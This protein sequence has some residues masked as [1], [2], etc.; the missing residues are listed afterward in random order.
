MDTVIERTLVL[1]KADVLERGLLGRVLQ[2][3]EDTGLKI[4]AA[5]LIQATEETARQHYAGTKAWKQRI[6]EKVKVA[7]SEVKMDIKGYFGTQDSL[8]IGQII[9]QW[10][11]DYLVS[12]PVL[13]LVI[14]GPHAV[15]RV[16]EI[17]GH[18]EPRKAARGTIRGDFGIDSIVY[19][20]LEHRAIYNMVHSSK[21]VKDAKRE[22]RVWFEK[23]EILKYK[24]LKSVN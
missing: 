23:G 12:N 21:T 13:A 22:I 14:E 4:V 20:N 7:F 16:E 24:G 5:K 9:H 15:E 10:S 11:I 18:T 2:R 6:G 3:F 17:S 19:A 8:L 1:A